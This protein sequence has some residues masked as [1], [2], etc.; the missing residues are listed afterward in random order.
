MFNQC[1]TYLRGICKKHMKTH[2][3]YFHGNI[4]KMKRNS[5]F[6]IKC[7][8][9]KHGNLIRFK[10]NSNFLDLNFSNIA[11]IQLVLWYDCRLQ[12]SVFILLVP[13]YNTPIENRN[14]FHN[15]PDFFLILRRNWNISSFFWPDPG[16]GMYQWRLPWFKKIDIK[17]P[18]VWVCCLLTQKHYIFLQTIS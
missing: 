16:R 5:C 15:R 18:T 7:R 13:G 17:Y 8:P 11:C 12:I 4:P 2:Q 1:S 14:F 3:Y 10:T 6:N 9:L